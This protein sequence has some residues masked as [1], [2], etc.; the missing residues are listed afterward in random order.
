ML[1]LKPL[2]FLK[3][4]TVSLLL[5]SCEPALIILP[6]HFYSTVETDERLRPAEQ[7]LEQ[8]NCLKKEK[9]P[10]LAC[11]T[12]PHCRNFCDDLF[13]NKRDEQKCHKWPS[14]LVNRFSDLYET[15]NKGVFQDISAKSFK[16]FIKLTENGSLLF[17]DLT[18]EESKEFLLEI[19]FNPNLAFNLSSADKGSFSVLTA[20]FRKLS[21][22]LISSAKEPLG[23]NKG[24]FLIEIYKK[25]NQPAW[26]WL[27][28]YLIYL[29]KKDSK[30]EEPLDYYCDILKNIK[31][32]ILEDFFENNQ[33]F[34]RGYRQAI[35]R[36]Q[37]GGSGCK[38]GDIQDFKQM[39]DNI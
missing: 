18:E 25:D 32:N 27:N 21:G 5:L 26:N 28:D 1:N 37:C 17:K 23:H 7:I 38:Y 14:R 2:F 16:C 6:D 24:N 4:F 31:T 35:Q 29:C 36:Q 30:C 34:E 9:N 13:I 15:M 22:R 11:W 33:H 8:E 12:V 3:I 39:C 19:A 20:L 10:D